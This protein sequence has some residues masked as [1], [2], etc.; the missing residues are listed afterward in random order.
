MMW[1]SSQPKGSICEVNSG[2]FSKLEGC[3]TLMSDIPKLGEIAALNK[4]VI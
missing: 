4:K 2:Y 3:T 1:I